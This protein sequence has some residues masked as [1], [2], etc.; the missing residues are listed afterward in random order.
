MFI[1]QAYSCYQVQKENNLNTETVNSKTGNK[2]AN[3]FSKFKQ[4]LN[5]KKRMF[6]SM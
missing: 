5:Y 6:Q 3:I 2:S 1:S 4:T